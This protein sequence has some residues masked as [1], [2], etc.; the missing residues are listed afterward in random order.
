MKFLNLFQVNKSNIM[1]ITLAEF[2]NLA[3][4]DQA[5]LIWLDGVYL[6]EYCDGTFTI[7]LYKVEGYY[8]EVYYHLLREEVYGYRSFDSTNQLD[9]YLSRIDIDELMAV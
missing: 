7:L 6:D 1:H 8:V 4:D 3:A 2:N 5:F 9:P